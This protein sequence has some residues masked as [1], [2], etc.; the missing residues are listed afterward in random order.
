VAEWFKAAVLIRLRRLFH[1]VSFSSGLKRAHNR[2]AAFE[3]FTVQG[4]GPAAVAQIEKSLCHLRWDACGRGKRV[5]GAGAQAAT[6]KAAELTI[7][8]WRPWMHP[9]SSDARLQSWRCQP[10]SQS[11]TAIRLEGQSP[12]SSRGP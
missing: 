5:A 1:R 3:L 7:S 11:V 8:K 6:D 12:R 2:V 10:S 9:P 4:R